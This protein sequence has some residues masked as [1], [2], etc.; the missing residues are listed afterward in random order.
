MARYASIAAAA[1]GVMLVPVFQQYG[2]IYVA[3]GRFIATVTPPMA[4]TVLLGFTWKRYT[5]KA[6]FLTLL[7]GGVAMGVA[8]FYPQLV[9]FFAHGVDGAEGHHYMR[10]LYGLVV[11]GVIGV[12]ATFFTKPSRTDE[13][14]VGYTMGT[15]RQ[16]EERFKGGP[17]NREVGGT[18]RAS[19]CVIDDDA[20]PVIRQ[21]TGLGE[22]P[23]VEISMHPDDLATLKARTGDL[24]FVEDQRWWLGG[25]R[26]AHVRVRDAAGERGVVHLPRSAIV[27]NNLLSDRPV[28]VEKMM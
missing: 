15:I 23:P 4:M 27:A 10:A 9:D 17:V 2:S 26:A 25:L 14:L 20:D 8:G 11:S 13:E 18:I 6:A 28:T 1:L 24:L 3:H 16:A 22:Q 21:V 19:L 5:A 12:A 7:G